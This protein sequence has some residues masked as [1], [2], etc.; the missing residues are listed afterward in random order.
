MLV[1]FQVT[2]AICGEP[3]DHLDE[4]GGIFVPIVQAS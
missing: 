3:Q 4:M 2:T 1:P